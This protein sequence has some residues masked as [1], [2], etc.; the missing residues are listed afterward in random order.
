MATKNEVA[1]VGEQQA[2][3]VVN[4]AFIDGLVSQLNEKVKFGLTFPKDYNYAN[5]LMGAYLCLKETKDKNDN[6]VLESCSQVSIANSLMRMVNSGLSMQ[7]GQCYP[8]AYGG[9][10]NIQPS[11]YGNTCN[12]RRYGLKNISAMVIYEGDVF[13]YHIV[14]A[15]IVIDKHV[16]DFFSIDTAKIVGAYAIAKMND[17]TQ[18]VE[19]M[20]MSMIKKA[21]QQGYSYKESA[22]GTHQKFTD[23]MCLKTV[24]NRCLKYIIRTHG[25]EDVSN[26]YDEFE[27][28]ESDD[29]VV[30]NVTHD[31]EVNANQVEVPMEVDD[32]VVD[33]QVVDDFMDGELPSF[34]SAE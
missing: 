2:S 9:K 15:E 21:W 3:L 25:S 12:A 5:E 8:I 29:R 33:P 13:E 16:Q 32:T 1:K 20:N 30:E 6:P 19:I 22:N 4:N 23:Q 24:K 34:M 27:E 11:V 31:I 26:A 14:D 28:H 18:H 17:G 10:L 7:N